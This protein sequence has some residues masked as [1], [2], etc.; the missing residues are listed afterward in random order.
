MTKIKLLT[1]FLKEKKEISIAL[2]SFQ[3]NGQIGLSA[4]GYVGEFVFNGKPFAI[5]F[6]ITE[7]TGS[8]ELVKRK[9]FIAEYLNVAGLPSAR[10]IV[11]NIAFDVISI[12]SGEDVVEIP[13][14]VMKRY[15]GTLKDF[16]EKDHSREKFLEVYEFLLQTL[17][18]IHKNGIVHRD[19][20]PEN[21]FIENDKLVL[22]DF[23]I[24]Y[25]EPDKFVVKEI[26]EKKERLGNRLFSAPE[27]EQATTDP[28]PTMD[29]YATGQVLQWFATSDTLKGTGRKPIR[30][31]YKN[32][33]VYDD[34]V[35]KCLS[36]NPKERFQSVEEIEE[37]YETFFEAEDEKDPFFI[38]AKF[39]EVLRKTFPKK[40]SDPI[41]IEDKARINLF[42]NNLRKEEEVFGNYIWY[43]KGF[44]NMY[45]TLHQLQSGNW[46]LNTDE[47]S[48]DKLFVT[49]DETELNDFVIVRYKAME[50]FEIDGSKTYYAGLLDEKLLISATEF[51]NGYAEINGDIVDLNDFK[52]KRMVC[53]QRE[54]GYLIISTKHSCAIQT[55]S[56]EHIDKFLAELTANEE[57]ALETFIDFKYR[58]RKYKPHYIAMNL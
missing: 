40:P 55:Q 23:G 18:F 30:S 56:D 4:N 13:L 49:Y 6:L 42:F 21:I 50:P 11:K 15:D 51:E 29:I 53:R 52:T 33:N 20:K 12:P 34:I 44:P 1:A 16:R 31:V 27:Q 5:K 9:R 35:E 36:Q 45:F 48:I 3:F 19:I 58:I 38:L 10:V 54:N 24:A 22:G 8:S 43:T 26:T 14:I 28:H 47:Y 32:M 57:K 37:Y 41:I 7:S 46:C 2:G 25:Y 17:K 39:N